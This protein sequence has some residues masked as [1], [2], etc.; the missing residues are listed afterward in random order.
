MSMLLNQC[1]S[2]WNY[3][4]KMHSQDYN[5]KNYV[6]QMYCLFRIASVAFGCFSFLL[7]SQKKIAQIAEMIHV[8]SLVHDDVIDASDLRR[9]KPSV[10]Q[11]WGHRKVG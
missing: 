4:T 7:S 8:A 11:A 5:A 2:I 10:M 6:K 9:G 3:E 1:C